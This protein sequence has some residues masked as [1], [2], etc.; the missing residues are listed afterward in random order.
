MG[1]GGRLRRAASQ[2][3]A[4]APA[5]TEASSAKPETSAFHGALDVHVAEDQPHGQCGRA[6]Q[7]DGGIPAHEPARIE[8]HRERQPQ[9]GQHFSDHTH[10]VRGGRRLRQYPWRLPCLF[11]NYPDRG[12][13]RLGQSRP[14]LRPGALGRCAAQLCRACADRERRWSAGRPG[15]AWPTPGAALPPRRRPHGTRADEYAAEHQ[16]AGDQVRARRER[17]AARGAARSS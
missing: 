17:S 16:H 13:V 7:R 12:P 5:A 3:S 14:D 6:E 15:A 11:S 9:H 2:A 8:P 10:P 1:S 4:S